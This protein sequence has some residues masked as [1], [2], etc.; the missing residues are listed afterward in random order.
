MFR[1]VMEVINRG[2]AKV[3]IELV[4]PRVAVRTPHMPGPIV[5][6]VLYPRS[7]LHLIMFL[8]MHPHLWHLEVR[9]QWVSRDEFDEDKIVTDETVKGRYVLGFPRDWTV[10]SPMELVDDAKSLVAFLWSAG[11][12]SNIWVSG[13][14]LK[15]YVK[16][17]RS[18]KGP[19]VHTPVG[20]TDWETF[21]EAY[22]QAWARRMID[23]YG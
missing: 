2:I 13:E 3:S 17:T 5:V 9:E 10:S 7:R 18:H 23:R 12:R 8:L 11:I 14:P 16:D 1:Q 15:V 22:D 21:L 19:R 4:Y 20:S 6:L